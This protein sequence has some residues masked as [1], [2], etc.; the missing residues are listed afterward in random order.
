MNTAFDSIPEP[1][2]AKLIQGGY[3]SVDTLPSDTESRY[4]DSVKSD[5]GLTNPQI[6]KVIN[7]IFRL[8]YITIQVEK[9]NTFVGG[10][11]SIPYSRKRIRW[12]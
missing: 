9:Y 5:C 10:S 6:N 8:Q 1:I 11:L 4:W 7:A 12:K 2:R 3:D